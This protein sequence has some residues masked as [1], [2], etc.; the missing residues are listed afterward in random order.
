MSYYFLAH[1]RFQ[2]LIDVLTKQGYAC[3]GPRVQNG[4][5]MLAPLNHATELPWGVQDEQGP[6]HYRLLEGDKKRAFAWSN[7]P[8]SLKPFLFKQQETLWHASRDEEGRYKFDP[9]I[10]SQRQALIGIRPCDLAAMAIQDKVFLEGPYI[11]TRYQARRQ[12]LFTVVVNC[13][14]PADTCFCHAQGCGPKANKAYDL[15]MS[16]TDDGLVMEA[17][18]P[19]GEEV[20]CLLNL[21]IAAAETV[22]QAAQEIAA[23]AQRQTRTTPPLSSMKAQFLAEGKEA[24][25]QAVS[26]PCTSCGSCTQVCPSC[27]CHKETLFPSMDGVG[28][29]KVREWDSCHGEAHSY[30]NHGAIRKEKHQRYRQWLSHK[31]VSWHEQ[32]GESGCVGCGRCISWCPQGIDVTASIATVMEVKDNDG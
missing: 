29:E 31:F 3:I 24:Q 1:K 6:A 2:S 8:S 17:G 30:L 32:F 5:I 9:V 26:D 23:A 18:S 4:G 13:T 22:E 19:A 21:P 16:E 25:W 7:S 28:G 11:D 27:F 10:E 20:L 15:A 14:H 12:S